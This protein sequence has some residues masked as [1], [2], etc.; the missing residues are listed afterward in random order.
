MFNL[1]IPFM[2]GITATEEMPV[3]E[4]A[5]INN[6]ETGVI[7]ITPESGK[8]LLISNLET[9]LGADCSISQIK[10]DGVD[11]FISGT[12][13]DKV[14]FLDLDGFHKISKSKIEVSIANAGASPVESRL[15]A[16]GLML[17]NKY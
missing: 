6:G 12:G 14:D 8:I 11:Q 10:V 4:V 3:S 16:R 5:T 13:A 9:K 1:N 17:K 2:D 7:T 15:I